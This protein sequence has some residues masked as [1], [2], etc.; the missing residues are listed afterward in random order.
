[1]I[2]FVLQDAETENLK[3]HYIQVTLSVQLERLTSVY[4]RISKLYSRIEIIMLLITTSMQS[5]TTKA[6]SFETL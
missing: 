6:M 4:I 5:F 3:C 2:G 1:M